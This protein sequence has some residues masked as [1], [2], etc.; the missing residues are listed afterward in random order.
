MKL[1][2]YC[3]IIAP[4]LGYILLKL[5]LCINILMS[6]LALV[7]MK[8]CYMTGNL[9]ISFSVLSIQHDIHEIES[10]QQW[11]RKIDI[12]MRRFHPIVSSLYRICCCQNWGP[13]IESCCYASLCNGDCLLLHD[14]MNSHS[15]MLLHL[16]KL[17]NAADTFVCKNKSASF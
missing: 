6:L 16:I 7:T 12:F 14:L 10:W 13:G 15:I 5:L 1:L 8:T 4:C 11:V 3:W 2:S 17:I 9:L